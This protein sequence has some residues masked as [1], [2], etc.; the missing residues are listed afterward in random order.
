MGS[1][2]EGLSKN[3]AYLKFE[4]YCKRESSHLFEELLL[5]EAYELAL[6]GLDVEFSV[7]LDEQVELALLDDRL[8]RRRDDRR[9]RVR[10]GRGN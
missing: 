7:R 4:E 3:T 6:G 8:R 1:R 9:R 10:R 2:C 5:D